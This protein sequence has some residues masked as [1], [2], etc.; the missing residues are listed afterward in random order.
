MNSPHSS[1]NNG[2]TNKAHLAEGRVAKSK[3]WY[4]C[5]TR[6]TSFDPEKQGNDASSMLVT[7]AGQGGKDG[8]N[9]YVR[10][11]ESELSN[12]T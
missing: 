6:W 12:S 5:C 11:L 2:S 10:L 1:K 3:P 8:A 9:E 7:I 4:L